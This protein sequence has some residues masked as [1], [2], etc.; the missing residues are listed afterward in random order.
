MLEMFC[1]PKCLRTSCRI[2]MV[3][4]AIPLIM[5]DSTSLANIKY[6][7]DLVSLPVVSVAPT[8]VALDSTS[9]L[10]RCQ[11]L[12]SLVR[13]LMPRLCMCRPRHVLLDKK[14]R[15]LIICT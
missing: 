10:A 2:S 8:L 1:C 9:M 6:A 14:M 11:L 4:M 5:L 12:G 7:L 15:S 3:G 13:R